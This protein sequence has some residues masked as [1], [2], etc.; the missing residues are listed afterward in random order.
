MQRRKFLGVLTAVLAGAL[1]VPALPA[2]ESAASPARPERTA[3]QRV[4]LSLTEAQ[5]VGQLFM[6]GINSASG[7]SS[8]DLAILRS[9]AIGNVMLTGR[10]AGG[11]AAK[12]SLTDQLRTSATQGRVAPF[13]AT[14]QEGG[15]VQVLS[16][17]GF[18]RMPT[19]LTQGGYSTTTLRADAHTWG[20]QLAAAG[21]NLNLAPVMDT[22]PDTNP[23]ANQPIGRYYREYGYTPGAVAAS[24]TAFL[25]GMLDAHVGTAIKH[26]P[27]LGRATGNTDVTAGVTD[28]TTRHDPYLQPFAAGIAAGTPFV[29]VSTATY[30]NIDPG[31]IAAFS[32]TVLGTVLRGDLGFTGAVI[33]D[34]LGNAAS[35]AA[36]SPGDR[37]VNFFNAGG[38]LLLSVT[39]APVPAMLAGVLAA[40]HGS[41]SFTARINAAVLHVL[42]AKTA[43]SLNPRTAGDF[44]G[45]GAADYAVYR[46]SDSTWYVDGLASVQ[47][48]APGDVPLR[49]DFTGDGRADYAVFRPSNGTWYVRCGGST[50]YGLSTDTPVPADYSGDGRADV[51]VFR[52]SSGTWYVRG[53]GS[54]QYGLSTDVPAPVDYNGDGR[55]DIAVFRPS[56]GTW[57]VRGISSVQYG[58]STDVPA[59][60]DYNGDGRADVA[61]FRPSNG[62]WYVRGISS[63]Q[64][65]ARRDLPVPADYTGAGHA[66]QAVFRPSNGTWYVRGVGTVQYGKAGDIPV[67]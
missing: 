27:G 28:P 14:D 43:A 4:L 36:V 38:D 32:S 12:R 31:H 40:M 19:A 35:V 54:V 11:T 48:G 5:R 41:A 59:P 64:Y 22:V 61:V 24:G 42:Q 66:D 58:L 7:P 33:S 67:S 18:S 30:P 46:P 51:A 16:G 44:T 34:D 13:I 39:S 9:D 65:G 45:D 17:P 26:F 15:Y 63:V 60:A 56:N 1:A 37:A 23:T 20:G 2:P 62:T 47:Y 29:M 53:A 6:V 3:A 55:A 57:Y 21:V 50:Q 10:S 52:P 8:S 49:G 25:Q